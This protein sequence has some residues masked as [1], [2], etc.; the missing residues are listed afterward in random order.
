[1][2]DIASR[3]MSLKENDQIYFSFSGKPEITTFWAAMPNDSIPSG[4]LVKT[5]KT[6]F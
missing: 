3:V 6:P 1:M 4:F 2:N 5:K